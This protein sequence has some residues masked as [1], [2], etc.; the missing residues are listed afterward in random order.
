MISLFH[1][2]RHLSLTIVPLS[3]LKPANTFSAQALK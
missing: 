2:P 3:F 1:S